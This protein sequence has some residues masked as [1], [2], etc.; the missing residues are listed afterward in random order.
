M[1]YQTVY[2][3]QAKRFPI[4]F[5]PSHNYFPGVQKPD[6]KTETRSR[7][8]RLPVLPERIERRIY[9]IRGHKVMVDSDLAAL[10]Q[11]QTKALNQ[12][13]RRNAERFPDDFMFQLTEDEAKN[14]RSQFVTSNALRGGRR[15]QPYAFT[16]H[17][18]L[19]LCSVLKSQRAIQMNILVVRAF[20]RLRELLASHK[21]LAERVEQLEIAQRQHGAVLVSVVKDIQKLKQPP[22]TRAIGFITRG[23]KPGKTAMA[24]SQL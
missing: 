10:Y 9:L 20:I 7:A 11:V 17:G 12:A 23:S 4:R 6:E 15:Y 14:L 13:V 18:V 16:E 19:M 3:K 2:R 21:A 8:N 1:I 5:C 24:P 22:L